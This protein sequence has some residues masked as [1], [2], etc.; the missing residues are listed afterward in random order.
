[1]IPRRAAITRMGINCGVP[2]G[3]SFLC[4]LTESV[5]IPVQMSLKYLLFCITVYMFILV[6]P[7]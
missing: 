4:H 7:G 3:Y 2:C 1:M 5:N 6:S